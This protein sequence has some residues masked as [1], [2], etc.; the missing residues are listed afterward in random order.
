[1]LTQGGQKF[2][3]KSDPKKVGDLLQFATFFLSLGPFPLSM[4]DISPER[5]MLNHRAAAAR[6][7]E[8][9]ARPRHVQE[10][11]EAFV[12]KPVPTKHPL[13]HLLSTAAVRGVFK[14]LTLLSRVS[15]DNSE[16]TVDTFRCR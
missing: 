5:G 15:R 4:A 9:S 6:L 16:A 10:P 2:D 3:F 8:T 14:E 12:V 13:W 1:M 11:L 7:S